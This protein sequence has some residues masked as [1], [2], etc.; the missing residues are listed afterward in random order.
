MLVEKFPDIQ[1]FFRPA[2]AT[3]QTLASGAPTTF[4]VRFMGRDVPGNLALA[5]ELRDRFAEE[6]ER[7]CGKSANARSQASV[8]P[9]LA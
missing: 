4:E 5:K 3:S 9:E 7:Y 8:A 1:S 2:D 6:Y